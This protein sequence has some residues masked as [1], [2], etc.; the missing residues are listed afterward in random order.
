MLDESV[1]DDFL[2][3][4]AAINPGNSGGPLFGLDGRVIGV[5]AAI[6]T[7]FSGASFGVPVRFAAALLP[8]PPKPTARPVSRRPGWVRC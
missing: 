3:T 4:D 5:N 6:L 1:Y 2:Q 8:E 7:E